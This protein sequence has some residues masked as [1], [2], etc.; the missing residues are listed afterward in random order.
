MKIAPGIDPQ[1]ICVSWPEQTAPF[2]AEPSNGLIKRER[3]SPLPRIPR[4]KRHETEQTSIQ[5][6]ANELGY[7]YSNDDFP[8]AKIYLDNQTERETLVSL[9]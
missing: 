3:G 5:T 9:P 1:S 7:H 6:S 4:L 8:S 2:A